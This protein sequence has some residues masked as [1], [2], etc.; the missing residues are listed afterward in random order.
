V[1]SDEDTAEVADPLASVYAGVQAGVQVR[2][3][4]AKLGRTTFEEDP[5]E[6]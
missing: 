5:T 2:L 4:G 1:L 6:P 3:F